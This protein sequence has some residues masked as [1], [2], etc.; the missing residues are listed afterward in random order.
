MEFGG[1][2]HVTETSHPHRVENW[3]VPGALTFTCEAVRALSHPE[4]KI[5]QFLCLFVCL[6]VFLKLYSHTE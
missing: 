3:V 5:P 6:F 4:S 1:H 2:I